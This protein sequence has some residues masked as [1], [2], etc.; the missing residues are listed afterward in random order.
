MNLIMTLLPW[1]N[2]AAIILLASSYL[3]RNAK[4]TLMTWAG[5][6][7]LL[8]IEGAAVLK[9]AGLNGMVAASL[10]AAV[11]CLMITVE[12]I[13]RGDFLSGKRKLIRALLSAAVLFAVLFFGSKPE[14]M[15]LVWGV[16]PILFIAFTLIKTVAH[17]E[18][19][20]PKLWAAWSI[21]WF[22]DFI[23]NSL[24]SNELLLGPLVTG[25]VC[26]GVSLLAGEKR[27]LRVVK[28]REEREKEEEEAAEAEEV[29]A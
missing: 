13:W 8:S 29:E 22:L 12:T 4:A 21:V 3:K 23:I 7:L 26:L 6:G 1:L 28:R 9:Y 10:I 11:V 18:N 5:T 27:T 20:S 25:L 16:G 2:L 15:R 14:T 24:G 17:P 19:E